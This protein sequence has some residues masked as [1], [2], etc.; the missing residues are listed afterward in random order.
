MGEESL[1]GAE[2]LQ[3][4]RVNRQKIFANPYIPWRIYNQKM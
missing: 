4:M 1:T 3:K 2:S